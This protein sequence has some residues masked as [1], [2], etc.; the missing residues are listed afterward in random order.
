MSLSKA[1]LKGVADALHTYKQELEFMQKS[2][3]EQKSEY[4]IYNQIKFEEIDNYTETLIDVARGMKDVVWDEIDSWAR[5]KNGLNVKAVTST[6]DD[7]DGLDSLDVLFL[8]GIVGLVNSAVSRRI[9]TQDVIDQVTRA[10]NISAQH[11]SELEWNKVLDYVKD[12]GFSVTTGVDGTTTIEAPE[13][14]NINTSVKVTPPKTPMFQA[15]NAKIA[16]RLSNYTIGPLKTI[17]EKYSPAMENVIKEGYAKHYTVDQIADNLKKVVDPDD[18]LNKTR[19][20]YERIAQT[21]MAYYTETAK[22]ASFE[23]TGITKVRWLTAMDSRVC[24]Q[25]IPYNMQ[26]FLLTELKYVPPL[27]PR[28]RCT[29]TPIMEPDAILPELLPGLYALMPQNVISA[30]SN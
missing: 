8:T 11:Y 25:C 14:F 13:R 24:N 22:L 26:I 20:I 3:S 15:A 7:D 2:Q 28:C 21:E 6:D 30:L 16:T 18:K 9:S 10:Y 27:H 1:K 19:H 4:D 12:R 5:H 17:G 23:Y 29:L